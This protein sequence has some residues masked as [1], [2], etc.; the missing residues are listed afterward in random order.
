MSAAEEA[1]AMPPGLPPGLD[2]PPGLSAPAVVAPSASAPAA[3]PRPS[4]GLI[5]PPG[6]PSAIGPPQPRVSEWVP[7]VDPTSNCIYYWNKRTGETSWEKPPGFGRG[8]V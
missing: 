3:R 4:G 7:T 2:L 6:P 1:P 8:I 5:G